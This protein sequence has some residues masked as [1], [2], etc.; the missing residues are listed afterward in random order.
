MLLLDEKTIET[1]ENAINNGDSVEVKREKDNIVVVEL[2]RKVKKT[3]I[4]GLAE[5]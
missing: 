3:P 4:N 5:S 2:R 1:I